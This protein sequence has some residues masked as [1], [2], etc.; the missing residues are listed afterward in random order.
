MHIV[1]QQ[2]DCE[3]PSKATLKRYL[4]AVQ[5]I[6]PINFAPA[7]LPA[8]GGGA[9]RTK[10]TDEAW[11]LF[12][13]I[14]RDAAPDFPLKQAWRDV[15]DL[16]DTNGWN[17]PSYPTCYRRW[18]ELPELQRHVARFGAK[19]ARKR[20]TQPVHRDKTSLMA[21]DQV[22][23]DGR[24][25]DFFVDMGDG[26]AVRPTMLVLTD[27]ATNKVIGWRLTLNENAVDTVQM[28]RDTCKEHGIFRRL[29]TD[30]GSAFAGNLVAGGNVHRFRNSGAKLRKVQPLGV[31]Y[32]LG[33][34]LDFHKPDNAKAKLAER[35]FSSISR[36]I[37]DRPEMKGIHAG[38]GVA[39]KP[40]QDGKPL[41]LDKANRL[42]AR[43]IARYN[44]EPGRRSQGANGR[45]YDQHFADDLAKQIRRVMTERQ[46]YLAGLIYSPAAVDRVGQ[47]TAE[48]TIYGGPSTQAALIPYHGDRQRVLLGRD[49]D[50]L[51]APALA[52]DE[53]G[54]LICE[55]IEC[56]RRGAY[57]SIEGIRTAER[58]R[59]AASRAIRRAEDANEYL[60][61]AELV[62]AL[63][64]LNTDS[65]EPPLQPVK[66][67]VGGRFGAPLRKSKEPGL[68]P[69]DYY[70]FLD[71]K[72]PSAK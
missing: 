65:P 61:N 13:T 51:A 4:K 40:D 30:N 46:G 52:F 50:D 70:E 19:D 71:H 62:A 27:I 45:S 26:R 44:A 28:I 2:T 10:P 18:K 29:S 36:V 24:T 60:T 1:A 17:W 6:D 55:G 68:N 39:G 54:D 59:K 53:N 57:N 72:L 8:Q 20:F 63:E 38:H 64:G 3:C 47:I 21:M 25:Q 32:H 23:M 15:R 5:G 58:N 22:S 35:T 31:C 41:T 14:I 42:I 34:K 16:A 48:G 7:L 49:P 12:M 37:D 9:P 33:I 67:V 66:K 43:E 11:S 56:I 69:R